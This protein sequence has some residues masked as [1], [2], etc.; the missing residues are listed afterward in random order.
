[1]KKADPQTVRYRKMASSVGL[2]YV[3]DESVGI[4]RVRRR[5]GFAY[6]NGSNHAVRD[7]STI[8]RVESLRIPP[9][10]KD[11]WI[12]RSPKGHL[13]ATGRDARGRKQ[14][15]YHDRWDRVRERDKYDRILRFAHKL[16]KIRRRIAQDL[17][18]PKLSREQV[19]ATVVR[20]LEGTL[21][22]VGN[23]EYAKTNGSYGLTTLRDKHVQ[24]RG[25]KIEFSFN[26]KSGKRHEIQVCDPKL[27]KTVRHCRD[28]PGGE[29]FQFKD[30][31]G[32]ICDVTSQDVNDYLR[33]IAGEDFTA[34]DYRTWA[35]TVLAVQSLR[36]LGDA[37]TKA[38]A[39]RQLVQAIDSVAE[40]LGNTRAV[41]RGSYIH[42]AVLDAYLDQTLLRSCTSRGCRKAC[43][44]LSADEQSVL[45][46]LERQRRK[47]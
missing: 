13:Q 14:Y 37:A 23:D 31:T 38:A 18:K 25:E 6:T 29:V 34:K 19:L 21:I 30:A 39:K 16:P 43:R 44:G 11:V 5:A 10:W 15:R 32:K 35:G 9:A 4:H 7:R 8:Q 36:K 22:R 47:S 45:R 24:V 41:C 46:W 28:L 12:C 26:G 27:A 20:L 2:Q 3:T 1:M 42:P 17:K 33:E 40:Q